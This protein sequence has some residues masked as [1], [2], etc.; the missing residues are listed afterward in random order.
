MDPANRTSTVPRF[1]GGKQGFRVFWGSILCFSIM[2]AMIS[3][4][5]ALQPMRTAV[6][7]HSVSI[8]GRCVAEIL[9]PL[10]SGEHQGT[11]QK[12]DG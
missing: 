12:A 11:A 4:Y 5:R 9:A 6:H 1:C 3:L 2:C 7:I 10:A 8:L